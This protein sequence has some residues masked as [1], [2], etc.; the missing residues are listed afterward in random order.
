M[1]DP[2]VRRDAVSSLPLF[3]KECTSAVNEVIFNQLVVGFF[4]LV[5]SLGNHAL[6][7]KQESGLDM[8]RFEVVL[9]AQGA[10]R[11]VGDGLQTFCCSDK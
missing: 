3:K 9:E 11:I 7:F 5:F 1:H 8:D 10:P 6:E 2:R 4:N